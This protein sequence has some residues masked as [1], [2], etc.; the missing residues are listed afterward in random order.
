MSLIKDTME[1]PDGTGGDTVVEDDG[2]VMPVEK[3]Y[4]TTTK[5]SCK[6]VHKE[7]R[8]N[9]TDAQGY[10]LPHGQCDYVGGRE[11]P[12]GNE[13]QAGMDETSPKFNPWIWVGWLFKQET[14]QLTL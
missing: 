6:Y 14:E 12:D 11:D 5:P 3:V 2:S 4:V 10:E 1:M 13:I 7:T 9:G 8:I